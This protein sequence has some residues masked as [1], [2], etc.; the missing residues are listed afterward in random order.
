MRSSLNGFLKCISRVVS[1]LLSD[2]E[3]VIS[4]IEFLIKVKTQLQILT[5]RTC[6]QRTII[7]YFIRFQVSVA[8]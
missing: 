6:D 7:Q 3:K 1:I 2:V 8:M 4:S 5:L